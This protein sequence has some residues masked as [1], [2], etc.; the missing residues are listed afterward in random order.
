MND[1]N[2]AAEFTPTNHPAYMG[3]LACH[4]CSWSKPLANDGGAI[5][6]VAERE[7]AQ[8]LID[9]HGLTGA[10]TS[11]PAPRNSSALRFYID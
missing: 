9:A 5:S 8:H 7:V 11:A 10:M 4:H 2:Y 3:T 6:E 1:D